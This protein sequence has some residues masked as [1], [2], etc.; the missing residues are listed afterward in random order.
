MLLAALIPLIIVSAVNFFTAE[1]IIF[2]IKVNQLKVINQ[3]EI[4][5]IIQIF[6]DIDKKI[7]EQ[8]INSFVHDAFIKLEKHINDRTSL[9]YQE[10]RNR[11][12]RKLQPL[13]RTSKFDDIYLLDSKGR[14][15]YASDTGHAWKY[16]GKPLY[17]DL[18][19]IKS[20]TKY[21]LSYTPVFLNTIESGNYDF[22]VQ[23]P[24]YDTEGKIYGA[25]VF[26]VTLLSIYNVISS[27]IG[28]GKTGESILFEK[29][30]EGE[31]QVVSPLRFNKRGALQTVLNIEPNYNADYVEFI[32]YQ[33]IES[34]GIWSKTPGFD[35]YLLSMLNKTEMFA[36]VEALKY[37]SVFIASGAALI[38]FLLALWLAFS[39]TKPLKSL[40][41][42]TQGVKEKNFNIYISDSLMRS[43]DEI[44]LLANS[45]KQMIHVLKDY[46]QELEVAKEQ[47]EF[48]NVS[49]TQFVANMSHEL[50]T[51]L[52]A[53]IGY[54]ELL[55]EDAGADKLDSYVNDLR[56]IHASGKHLLRLIDDV[57]D[58][59]KI[60][61]GKIEILLEDIDI[62]T[63]AGSIKD[64]IAPVV[65]KNNN[66]FI[67][68]C[69]SNIGAMHT[70]AVR[71]R[72]S[73]I[74]LLSNASKFTKNG[75][76]RLTVS[77]HSATMG[78]WI[79]FEIY[80]TGIGMTPD[81]ISNLF[82]PFTQATATT[83]Q[84]FGGTG[85][86]LYLTKRFCELLGGNVD[87]KSEL[88]K[89]ST[90]TIQLPAT[91]NIDTNTNS[92][93]KH[94]FSKNE[95][96][97]VSNISILII[98]DEQNAH[99]F[100]E[101]ALQYE[102]YQILH[103]YNGEEG[104]ALALKHRPDVITLDVIMPRMDG[105]STLS[106]L[107]SNPLLKNIPI[108]MLTIT[109]DKELGLA[110]NVTDYL[111]KPIEPSVLLKSIKKSIGNKNDVE[112]MIIDDDSASSDLFTRVI[113]RTGWAST[114]ADGAKALQYLEKT[115]RL[116]TLILLDLMM[117][118][119][120]GFKILMA[121]QQNPK[122]VKIP[123]IVVT[124]K[125]L[126]QEELEILKG[127]TKAIFSKGRY[128]Q[129]E[130]LTEIRNKI[131]DISDEVNNI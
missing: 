109:R 118:E 2:N 94:A 22:L 59:S 104:L 48:A 78:D 114:Q 81:Q 84:Q 65:E 124:A 82:K 14:V 102:G 85:L 40:V 120:D 29:R 61:A 89:G 66:S 46:Y 45:F 96:S 58:L 42:A 79:H 60:E 80:D 37:E 103:A 122:W 49:K 126:T 54:S 112:I 34:I 27:P 125:D 52:N 129:S 26:D 117:P 121:L 113:R 5:R 33:G 111:I 70:D 10:A 21:G 92:L 72:Q 57:L 16:L 105:W 93:T 97:K 63:F 53:I 25:V 130:L 100:I 131:K 107:K 15:I 86:G 35:F 88:G 91:S 99:S 36:P 19:W 64:L 31:V 69:P 43:N 106:I 73:V 24:L 44:A 18:S 116:P 119:V 76:V 38:I 32:D 47:A 87:V 28:L 17:P 77:R 74:N 20:T 98:D 7:K 50:R 95:V 67:L 83:A 13:Q 1:K 11:L 127:R 9:E 62:N 108:I 8:Q 75:E 56:K 12:D 6:N 123:V 128:T 115:T 23:G 110:M 90:F 41:L 68:I 55:M 71:M 39:I 4:S 51:P 3:T 101:E 30:K